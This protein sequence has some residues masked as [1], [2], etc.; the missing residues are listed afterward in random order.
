[1]EREIPRKKLL[2]KYYDAEFDKFKQL[3]EK[4]EPFA[5][6]RFSDG[7]I[8]LLKS[9]KVVLHDT[10]FICGDDVGSGRYPS[11]EGKNVDP[12]EHP[13]VIEKL[14]ECLKASRPN[15]FK[16]LATNEDNDVCKDDNILLYQQNICEGDETHQ[17]FANLFING[18]YPRFINEIVPMLRDKKVVFVVNENANLDQLSF[19]NI[20]KTFSIGSNCI[21]NDFDISTKINKWVAQENISDTVFLVAASTLS[22]FIIKDCFF[23]HPQNTYIDIGSSLNPWMG[24][25][26]WRYSRAYLQHWVLGM[27]N[28][29]GTQIDTW[30]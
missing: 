2:M 1:M 28:K 7:E 16:A 8:N 9:M 27:H 20:I 19:N 3:L 10:G 15:Y 29:Y 30:S 26:G 17:T 14:H 6:S 21:V 24:L 5:Y 18:N 22:N 23:E 25:E 4:G 12:D 13:H 11:E